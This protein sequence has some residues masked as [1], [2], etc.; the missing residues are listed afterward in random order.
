VAVGG[1]V[2]EHCG[3]GRLK[4]PAMKELR[5]ERQYSAVKTLAGTVKATK[6][7][8]VEVSDDAISLIG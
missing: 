2:D 8:P 7:S 5:E 3:V 4:P 6:T 1:V